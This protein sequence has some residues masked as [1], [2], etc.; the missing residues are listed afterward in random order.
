MTAWRG[1]GSS[2]SRPAQLQRQQ[3]RRQQQALS[4]Q[5]V[6]AAAEQAFMAAAAV[7]GSSGGSNCSRAL[8]EVDL[9]GALPLK[10]A[11]LSAH[12]W[13][14]SCTANANTTG[15]DSTACTA[16]AGRQSV[17]MESGGPWEEGEPW[18][19]EG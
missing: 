2:C 14:S 12:C 18:R 16:Q 4:T 3:E 9:A 5:A 10:M 17:G 6:A 7:A 1:R 19:K 11:P 13:K 8:C 15:P